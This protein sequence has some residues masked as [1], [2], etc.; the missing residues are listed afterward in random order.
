M[1]GRW[2][3]RRSAGSEMEEGIIDRLARLACQMVAGAFFREQIVGQEN[4]PVRGPALLVANHVT[5]L[6]GLLIGA[7][8]PRMVRFLVWKP[9]FTIQPL[10]WVFRR[11]RAI[12]VGTDNLS[13][14]LDAIRGA[15]K[16]LR[17]GHT[18]CIFAEGSITRTG[19]LL[20]FKRGLEKIV[21]GLDV[22]IVPM[23]LDGLWGSPF[24]LAGGR[25]AGKMA[26]Q[27]RAP[28]TISFGPWMPPAS[29]AD[30]VRQAIQDLERA[31]R[32]AKESQPFSS[33]EV[34]H[35]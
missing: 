31:G 30:Q 23:H 3:S 22:P 1:F 21:E 20:P 25:I 19:E 2:S 7:C 26:S 11:I 8:L 4:V 5:F 33:S 16:A 12:P 15:R 10:E 34:C 17:E 6:D 29:T 32:R 24:S 14:V 13:E 27:L 35:D 28:V 9:Y 18:V